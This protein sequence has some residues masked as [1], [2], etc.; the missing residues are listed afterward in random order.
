VTSGQYDGTISLVD[1]SNPASPVLLSVLRTDSTGL[2]QLHNPGSI[3]RSGNCLAVAAG[4]GADSEIALYDAQNP[5]QPLLQGSIRNTRS[6]C[7]NLNGRLGLAFHTTNLLVTASESASFSIIHPATNQVSLASAGWVGIGT[8]RPAAAL[9]VVGDL[10]VTDGNDIELRARHVNLGNYTIASGENSTAMGYST[11]ASGPYSTAMG[12][13]T[14][15][16]GIYSTAMGNYTTASDYSS[17]AMGNYT[18]ASGIYS[19]AMG[20]YTTASSASSTAMGDHATASGY[21]STAMGSGTTASGYNSTTMGVGTRASGDSSTAMGS[22]TTASANSST[23]M[24]FYTTAS[25]Y[26]STA[27]GYQTTATNYA[28]A[29]GYRS[30]AIHDGSFVWADPTEADFSS[31]GFNQFLI[32]ASGGVGINTT[33]TGGAALTVNGAAVA[34]S[35]AGAGGGLTGLNASQLTSGTLP[36][37][38]LSASVAIRGGG[39]AFSG[40][41]TIMPGTLGIGTTSPQ[42]PLHV[43]SANSLTTLRLQS[44]AAPGAGRIEFM[45]DP[46]GSASEWR[47]AYIQSTD[48]GGFMGGLAFVVNGAGFDNRLGQ[49]ETMRV[50]NGRVGIGTTTPSTPLHVVGTVTA[51]TFSPTSDRHAKEN[52]APV[53]P[54]EVLAKVAALPISRWNF[55][56]EA[57]AA[58]VGPMAQDFKAAFGLGTDDKHIAT[59]DADGVALA[60]IQGLNQ[61][62]E[63]GKRRA[64]LEMAE[65]KAENAELR[66][67][68]AAIKAILVKLGQVKE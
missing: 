16:S 25:G 51:T 52:F 2:G 31:S 18:T 4:G 17:T 37:A 55:K 5:A 56:G 42:T 40:T 22:G 61:K 13:R 28:F 48:N 41:Q 44:A 23:A 64:E 39:N 38:R 30:K 20:N 12:Y 46:Q 6:G 47:P 19:T 24:G 43:Y 54:A 50:V 7:Y 53:S 59:V 9:Q 65:L 27:M 34:G 32:R 66:Q 33:N 67:E 57:A 35:F 1:A 14:T 10:M 45:S 58:H 11:T 49:V 26:S 36:D 3:A 60:A 68:L 63:T 62:V 15:A 21:N 29:A 8:T